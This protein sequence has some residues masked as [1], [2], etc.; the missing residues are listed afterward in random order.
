MSGAKMQ[1][2]ESWCPVALFI[3]SPLAPPP[4]IAMNNENSK[5]PALVPFHWNNQEINTYLTTFK[6]KAS[7]RAGCGSN[8][9]GLLI[10]KLCSPCVKLTIIL[11]KII[12]NKMCL[13]GLFHANFRCMCNK[14]NYHLDLTIGTNTF[15]TLCSC[16]HWGDNRQILVFFFSKAG[17]RQ[18]F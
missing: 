3:G 13:S 9:T 2:M 12:N 14:Q 1:F 8:F 17:Q 5:I 16:A 4:H 10:W 7:S 18:K 6:I 15:I 11:F